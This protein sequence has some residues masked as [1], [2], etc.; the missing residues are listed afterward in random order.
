[1]PID[2]TEHVV[3]YLRSNFVGKSVSENGIEIDRS[4]NNAGFGD[5]TNASGSATISSF[6]SHNGTIEK[7]RIF[8]GY[9]YQA[10]LNVTYS[11]N[12]QTS[13]KKYSIPGGALID[14]PWGSLHPSGEIE[15]HIH[16]GQDT[17]WTVEI[18]RMS[19]GPVHEDRPNRFVRDYIAVKFVDIMHQLLRE[20]VDS[21]PV[22]ES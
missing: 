7:D 13:A 5:R 19:F 17:N 18:T 2:V 8:N 15:F 9:G 12:G 3:N 6:L 20:A 22:P 10:E 21:S 14:H 16:A 11:Y 4:V 1:M